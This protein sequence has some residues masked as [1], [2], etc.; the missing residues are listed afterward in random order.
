MSFG[1]EEGRLDGHLSKTR[2][3]RLKDGSRLKYSSLLTV[4][5]EESSLSPWQE[6][7]PPSHP[8]QDS[9]DFHPWQDSSDFHPWQGPL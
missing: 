5:G 6:K 1:E 8:W 2:V 9:S 4:A 7:S 3:G